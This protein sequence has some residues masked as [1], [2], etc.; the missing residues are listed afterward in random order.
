MQDEFQ[1]MQN[2]IPLRK[3]RNCWLGDVVGCDLG[4]SHQGQG[5]GHQGQYH[6]DFPS[7]SL[8]SNFECFVTHLII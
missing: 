4:Q 2:Q 1:T 6:Q 5:H 7:L 3:L 8:V